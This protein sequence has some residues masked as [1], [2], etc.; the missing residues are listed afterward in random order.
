MDIGLLVSR[1]QGWQGAEL[2]GR[3]RGRQIMETKSQILAALRAGEYKDPARRA[4][5]LAFY[6]RHFGARVRATAAEFHT[7]HSATWEQ[8][9]GDYVSDLYAAVWEQV[10]MLV[11]LAAELDVARAELDAASFPAVR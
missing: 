1:W 8:I 4:L 10:E 9:T 7:E 2:A 6:V 11:M 5:A 3:L